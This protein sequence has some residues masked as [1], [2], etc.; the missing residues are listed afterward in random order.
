MGGIL[1]MRASPYNQLLS[2]EKA[3]FQIH[4][5]GNINKQAS[6]N[7]ILHPPSVLMNS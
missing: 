4:S 2:K 3:I 5:R 1:K 6:M 7:F